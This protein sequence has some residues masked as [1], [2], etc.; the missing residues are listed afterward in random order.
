MNSHSWAM[1][2]VPANSPTPIERAGLTDVAVAAIDAKWITARVRPMARGASPLSL[3]ESVT[4]STTTTSRAVIS[5]SIRKAAHQAKPLPAVP[6]EFWPK[7]P[8]LLKSGKPCMSARRVAPAS[9]APAS[10]TSA[11]RPARAQDTRPSRAA[12]A[13]SRGRSGRRRCGRARRP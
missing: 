12:R 5:T 8:A 4:A 10:C 7:C 9:S 13:R 2:S 6:K 3:R 1:A 11:Y